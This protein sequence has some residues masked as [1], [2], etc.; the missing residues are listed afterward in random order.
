MIFILVAYL[1]RCFPL[2]KC[3]NFSSSLQKYIFTHIWFPNTRNNNNFQQVRSDSAS[4]RVRMWSDE[5]H[6]LWHMYS[7]PVYTC[8][9]L[10]TPVYTCLHL[11][12]IVYTCLHLFTLVYNCLYLFSPVCTCSHLFILVFIGLHLFAPDYTC[13]RLFTLVYTYLHFFTYI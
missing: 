13:L 2:S 6:S 12:T 11:F 9:Y 7:T 5:V 10:C 4:S 1:E 8:L 3:I